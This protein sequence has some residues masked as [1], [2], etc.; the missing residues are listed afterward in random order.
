[1]STIVEYRRA[2]PRVTVDLF[3]DYPLQG[4]SVYAVY[5][6]RQHVDAKIRTFV[7]FLSAS[8]KDKFDAAPATS[9]PRV[10]AQEVTA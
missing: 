3:P 4:A 7:E 10:V 9:A 5:P 8:L 2:H 6:S 1:M